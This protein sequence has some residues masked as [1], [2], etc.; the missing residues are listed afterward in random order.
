MKKTFFEVYFKSLL[1]QKEILFAN[2]KKVFPRWP[3]YVY[4]FTIVFFNTQVYKIL[5]FF[6]FNPPGYRIQPATPLLSLLFPVYNR[7]KYLNRSFSSIFCQNFNDFE[8]VVSDDCSTDGTYQYMQNISYP[9]LTI[10][11]NSNHSGTLITRINAIRASKGQYIISMDSDDEIYCDL[12]TTL[13]A[14]IKKN[15]YDIFQYHLQ[16]FSEKGISNARN[17]TPYKQTNKNLPLP[18]ESKILNNSM[19]LKKGWSSWSLCSICCRRYLLMKGIATVSKDLYSFSGSE[20]FIIFF[21]TIVFCRSFCIIDY[22]GYIYYYKPP[23]RRSV[24]K[25][26]NKCFKVACKYMHN[27][28]KKYGLNFPV[29]C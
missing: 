16:V 7:L 25:Y 15:D 12:F 6:L 26:R 10:V 1:S 29:K 17:H 24:I 5:P 9:R 8:I 13:A 23:R 2:R 11:Q 4:L 3:L 27:H 14:Y 19:L 20:D 28:W 18:Y 21:S 22:F